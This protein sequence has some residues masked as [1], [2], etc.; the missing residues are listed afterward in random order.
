MHISVMNNTSEVAVILCIIRGINGVHS[1]LPFFEGH[2]LF[3][4]NVKSSDDQQLVPYFWKNR[5]KAC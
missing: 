1:V 2:S 5:T 3:S 4:A